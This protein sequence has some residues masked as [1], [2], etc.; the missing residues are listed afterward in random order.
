MFG[1]K[2]KKS[3]SRRNFADSTDS[4]AR[5]PRSA[6]DQPHQSSRGFP[7]HGTGGSAR[8]F[9]GGSSSQE[10][11]G[12]STPP[13]DR[14]PSPAGS[15][16]AR[17]PMMQQHRASTPP[18]RPV[19]PPMQHHGASTP[20]GGGGDLNINSINSNSRRPWGA[21]AGQRNANG[22]TEEEEEEERFEKERI[23]EWTNKPSRA[24]R[25]TA[26]TRGDLHGVAGATD[27]LYEE[28][29]EDPEKQ[30]LLME[31]EEMQDFVE[32]FKEAVDE[33]LL[34][35][36]SEDEEDGARSGSNAR[37]QQQFNGRTGKRGKR[38]KF[39]IPA[40]AFCQGYLLK[41]GTVRRKWLKR[42]FVVDLNTA[43][44]LYYSPNN[45]SAPKGYINLRGMSLKNGIPDVRHKNRNVN[46]DW[47]FAIEES[48][49]VSPTHLPT[50]SFS[51]FLPPFSVVVRS[52]LFQATFVWYHSA[53]VRIHN[54]N[55]H[56]P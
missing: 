54:N 36:K 34:H 30:K 21:D 38:P 56:S 39:A 52:F 51:F 35:P 47:E 1:F 11:G 15:E 16:R 22:L 9:G 43:Q 46:S 6:G 27:D 3:P 17:S 49:K 13:H 18:L 26:H 25:F 45:S 37:H 14:Q 48:T 19:T 42:L 8:N 28:E 5:E 10:S 12:G 50:Q 4:F 7:G 41:K 33:D 32:G 55:N 29:F 24:R 20:N 2:R 40:D 53:V 44:L 31:L 23:K